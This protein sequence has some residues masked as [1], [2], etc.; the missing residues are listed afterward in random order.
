MTD[1]RAACY[2]GIFSW[3]LAAVVA[4]AGAGAFLY[5]GI[6]WAVS[7]LLAGGAVAADFAFLVLFSVAWLEAARRGGHRPVLKGI[8]ALIAKVAMPVAALSF[9]LRFGVV[10]VYPAVSAALAVATASPV[11]LL[12]LF[13]REERGRRSV[14]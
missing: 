7:A 13:L 14:P 3:G 5:G 9:L 11:I 10:D 2:P 8:M 12:V 6:R 4:A 1:T